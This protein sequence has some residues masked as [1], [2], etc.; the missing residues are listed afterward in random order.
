M[1]LQITFELQSNTSF[2]MR[3]ALILYVSKFLVKYYILVIFCKLKI[4]INEAFF[5]F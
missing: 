3:N 4:Q 1:T 2:C 5:F